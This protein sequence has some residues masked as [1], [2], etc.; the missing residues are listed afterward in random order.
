MTSHDKILQLFQQSNE[1]TVKEIVD[2]LGISKQMAHLA[3]NRLREENRLERLGSPPKTIYRFISSPDRTGDVEE[4]PAPYQVADK[5]KEFLTANFTVVTES[6]N[7]LEGIE[8]FE[9]WCHARKLPVQKTLNEFV[10]T[11]RRYAA[12]YDSDGMINGSEKL[13]NTKGYDKI[14]LDALYYLDF[15]AI[16][17]FG[18]TRLGTLLHY[19]KQGQNKF[20]MR[21]MMDVIANR[22]KAFIRAHDADA[23]GFVPPTIRREVQLMKFIQ[24]QLNLSLP[25]IEI[26]KISGI[27]PVPQ[28]SL[29]KLD[30]R[31]RNAE[32]TFAVTD[33]RSFRHVVL[34][35]DAVGSGATLN[36]IAAKIRNKNVAQKITG[37]AIV[38]SFKGFDV[39]T[40]I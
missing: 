8:A 40:D 34:I 2:R 26:K 28:K 37:L 4:P 12:Y 19:A 15:Y 30:E 25:V 24:T 16:E 3:I 13:K 21:I 35:D 23:I 14:W 29:S 5:E 11:K 1:L 20:L 31:I 18:K 6:G 36:Q 17:R 38:G 27:I 32:N 22:I 7:L 33:R 39:I 9:Y 10:D